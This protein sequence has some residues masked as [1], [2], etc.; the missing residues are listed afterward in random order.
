[1]AGSL[2]YFPAR[3]HSGLTIQA[4]VG[5]DGRKRT[6]RVEVPVAQELEQVSQEKGV[7]IELPDVFQ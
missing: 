7:Q 2:F 6:L 5:T 4:T 3:R 1:M